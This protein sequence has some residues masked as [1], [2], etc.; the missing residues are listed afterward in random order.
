MVPMLP[1]TH[2]QL[3]IQGATVNSYY[4]SRI[5]KAAT[6]PTYFTYLESKYNWNSATRKEIDWSNYKQTV[7]LFRNSHIILVKHVHEIAP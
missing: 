1:T 7:H 4:K 2:A 6:L 5:R 3:I